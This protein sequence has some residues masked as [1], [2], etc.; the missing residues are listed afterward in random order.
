MCAEIAGRSS[1][2]LRDMGHTV[3]NSRTTSI[4]TSSSSASHRLGFILFP[5]L[6]LVAAASAQDWGGAEEQLAQKIVAV[7]GQRTVVL[8]VSN[9]SSLSASRVDDI[10]RELLTEL[11]SKGV[12]FAN[13][14]QAG[15]SVQVFLSENLQNYL[16]VA[17]I[18]FADQAVNDAPATASV[19]MVS[20]PRPETPAVEIDRPAMVLRKTSLWSQKERILD[21]AIVDG[22]PALNSGRNSEGNSAGNSPH[23]LVLDSRGV[24]LYRWQ[25]GRWMAEQSLTISHA[26]PWPRDLRG[27]IVLRQDHLFDAYLPGVSCRS[28]STFPLA[29]TCTEGEMRGRLEPARWIGTPISF[30]LEI[31]SAGCCSLIQESRASASNNRWGL[32]ILP[33]P[34]R[35]A[36][37]RCGS[38]PEL[39]DKC[40]CSTAPR[41]R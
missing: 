14:G 20:L 37:P 7:T 31:I 38:L 13:T 3:Y 11:A 6:L 2:A 9:R 26:R 10:R 22:N 19:V 16:W 35:A 1:A 28:T 21:V 8:E 30:L 39:T 5:I 25:D 17:E 29:M 36:N 32:F 15:A 4:L 34:S 18:R 40:T 41:I 12:R 23:M 27:R 33:R 24:A